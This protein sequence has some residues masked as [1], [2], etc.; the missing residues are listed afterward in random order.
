MNMGR[1]FGIRLANPPTSPT[2]T[3]FDRSSP[4]MRVSH[5]AEPTRSLFGT[6]LLQS[7]FLCVDLG[8][9]DKMKRNNGAWK[10]AQG[11]TAKRPYST[12]DLRPRDGT[13]PSH[14]SSRGHSGIVRGVFAFGSGTR[15]R[16]V[17]QDGNGNLDSNWGKTRQVF[18][19]E[20]P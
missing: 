9:P 20:L 17:G 16:H 8:N 6:S 15:T 11:M 7:C 18:A 10:L 12:D 19:D 3:C 14:R 4:G 5:S 13:P 2:P 1:N